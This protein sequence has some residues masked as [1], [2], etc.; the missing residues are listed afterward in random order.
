VRVTIGASA[1]LWYS[2]LKEWLKQVLGGYDGEQAGEKE[3]RGG[4][5]PEELVGRLS[6]QGEW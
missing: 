4:K 1:R 5:K 3:E 6:R 2:F